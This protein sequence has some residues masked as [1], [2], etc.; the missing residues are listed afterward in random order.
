MLLLD[1]KLF[2][3]RFIFYLIIIWFYLIFISVWVD[4]IFD[5]IVF[6]FYFISIFCLFDLS[7]SSKGSI[8]IYIHEYIFIYES[9]MRY[10]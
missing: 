1:L 10:I 8:Y 6:N 7:D 3:V 5:L 4:L 9:Y 2:I